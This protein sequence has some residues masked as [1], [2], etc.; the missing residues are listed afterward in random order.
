MEI[1]VSP[2][3]CWYQN[4][5]WWLGKNSGPALCSSE[6]WPVTTEGLLVYTVLVTGNPAEPLRGAGFPAPGRP[7]WRGTAAPLCLRCE[8]QPWPLRGSAVTADA[9]PATAAPYFWAP[10]SLLWSWK[11]NTAR[12][13]L[14]SEFPFGQT[15]LLVSFSR[16]LPSALLRNRSVVPVASG[17]HTDATFDGNISNV[18]G[19]GFFFLVAAVTV[20]MTPAS[21]FP[22]TLP[23]FHNQILKSLGYSDPYPRY[24]EL[25]VEAAQVWKF[26]IQPQWKLL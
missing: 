15:L 25:R 10:S 1:T 2:V 3:S 21:V 4:S 23:H 24:S 14:S 8:D 26:H 5:T 12:V 6:S 9:T 17:G 16:H 11:M 13:S 22:E 19:F 18:V 7:L 20:Y